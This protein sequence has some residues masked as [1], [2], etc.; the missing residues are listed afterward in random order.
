M[1]T[2]LPP[3]LVPACLSVPAAQAAIIPVNQD[4]AG[5]GLNDPTA[6]APEGITSTNPFRG[7]SAARLH[8]AVRSGP[9]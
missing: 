6:R 5:V 8:A 2:P 9:R 1:K 7:S 3:P 4:G